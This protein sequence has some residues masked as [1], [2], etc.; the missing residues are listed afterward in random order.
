MI[1]TKE[2]LIETAVEA[3]EMAAGLREDERAI[4]ADGSLRDTYFRAGGYA[5]E[6][7]FRHLPVLIYLAPDRLEQTKPA[8]LRFT[9]R[10]VR[11]HVQYGKELD[12]EP[13]I[14]LPRWLDSLEFTGWPEL[15]SIRESVHAC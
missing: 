7:V 14:N 12:L 11:G 8:L 2:Q 15:K 6:L 4:F 10:W 3:I 9:L 13:V 1:P 5:H